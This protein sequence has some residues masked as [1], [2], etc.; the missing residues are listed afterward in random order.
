MTGVL[1]VLN[2]ERGVG[3]CALAGTDGGLKIL[4][5]KRYPEVDDDSDS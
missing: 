2:V 3:V 5:I 4:F 1:D